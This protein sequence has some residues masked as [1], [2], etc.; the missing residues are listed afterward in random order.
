MRVTKIRVQNFR[1]LKD[2]LIDLE[3]ELS[4]I[5]GKNNCGKTSLLLILDKFLGSGSSKNSLTFDD[6][7]VDFKDELKARIESNKT[8]TEDIPFLGISLKLF[9]EYDESDDLSNIGNK[10]IMD[11]DPDNKVVVLAFEYYLPEDRFESLKRDYKA[12][13]DKKSTEKRM[14]KDIFS[15]LRDEHSR[16]FQ[17]SKK[18]IQYN[19][20]LKKEDETVFTDLIKEKVQIDKIINFKWISARRNVSNKDT[21]KALSSQSSRMYKRLESANSN[22]D[23]IEDFKDAL[24]K[25]DEDLDGIYKN[26]FKEVID[27]IKRFGGIKQ[28]DSVI[29]I[30]SSLRHKELL[31]ENTTVM[32]GL[33]SAD[34]SLPE[35]YNG[36]GY[37][38]LISMIF[39]IKILLH[40]F[41]KEKDEKPSDINLLFIE[42]P[43]AHTHPQMQSIFIKNIKSLLDGG[44]Q[45][46]DGEK[47]GL[48]TILST[49]SS[50]I[51]SESN[52]EDI[53]YFKKG[54]DGI[55]SRNLKDLEKEYDTN[56][57]YYKFLKQ[58]LTLHRSEL[59]FADKV[60]FI[61][62]DTERIL[63]PAMMKKLDQEDVQQ[64][65]QKGL[66]PSL[67]LLS[68]NISVIE[69][70]AYSHVFEKFIDFISMKSLIITDIDSVKSVPKLDDSGVVIKNADGTD[71]SNDESCPVSEGK[72]T[73]NYS[74]K[75]FYG[76]SKS[77]AD[78]IALPLNERILK[79]NA[80]H[81]KWELNTQGHLLCV[82]QTKETASDG[83]EYHARSFEDAFLHINKL[84]IKSKIQDAQGNFIKDNP[85]E[86][87]TN[88]HLNLFATSGNAY[89][90]ATNGV[91]SKPS[92]AMEILLNSVN[93]EI[94]V[95]NAKTS[96]DVSMAME[97]SNWSVP[98]YIREG[99]QWLKQD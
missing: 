72:Q 91:G 70:G 15:Y 14:A 54:S 87:L 69:V 18:S 27:D 62:G 25:T 38:N 24:S 86:S 84:F 28:D 60:I 71:K 1:L 12:H 17:T 63:L 43:E 39:E 42:E 97:F 85:F 90:L 81:K 5:I 88:K 93:N 46:E 35:N 41:Q 61:E 94:S 82:Y 40:E 11:L 30:V 49:H 80:N 68:Q 76:G 22:S 79:K 20:T 45:R 53:K 59:F 55:I 7:N 89:E 6:F 13:C 8:R 51:V 74:L 95:K 83:S 37:M 58:Y 92:F 4:V 99:L 78:F 50:H 3:D 66:N 16:Y 56:N 2:I 75:F 36:L 98:A 96:Q 10:V 65:F 77:L 19:T 9:V 73:S 57:N 44:I 21:E 67:P 64:E 48:Q 47:R 33:G 31:E 23:V 32:Y 26:I 34:H 52:F 29:K